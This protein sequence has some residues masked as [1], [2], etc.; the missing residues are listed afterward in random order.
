MI[1]DFQDYQGLQ[2]LRATPDQMGKKDRKETQGTMER[3]G[4]LDSGVVRGQLAPEG[5]QGPQG[6]EKRETKGPLEMLGLLVLRVTSAQS[7]LKARQ[8]L[9][10]PLVLMVHRALKASVG[11][12]DQ[13]DR[14][15]REAL[16][17]LR[18]SKVTMERK[19]LEVP[20]V[21]QGYQGYLD[22]LERKGPKGLQGPQELMVRKDK[23]VI[24]VLLGYQ[25]SGDQLDLQEMLAF[26]ALLGFKDHQ[27]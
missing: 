1:T 26:Q 9:L 21:N 4:Y 16:M 27:G 12:Q 18:E 22:L 15:E 25:G 11:N 8:E 24:R 17:D 2:V 5:S 3:R 20:Q 23:E 19:D 7:G 14:R 10:D 13:V 6:L